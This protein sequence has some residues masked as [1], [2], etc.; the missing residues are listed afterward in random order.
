MLPRL[1]NNIIHNINDIDLDESLKPIAL[2]AMRKLQFRLQRS[3]YTR[4]F[5]TA[6]YE[7]DEILER[8]LLPTDGKIKHGIGVLV[9]C[10]EEIRHLITLAVRRITHSLS[11]SVQIDLESPALVMTAVL[12]S[13]QRFPIDMQ[14]LFPEFRHEQQ[15]LDVTFT[16]LLLVTLKACLRSS[17]LKTSLDSLPLMECIAEMEDIIR[18]G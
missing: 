5:A 8:V 1:L 3:E 6:I 18:V 2:T 10:H 7:L 14:A 17:F 15:R 9:L 16:T 12:G 11:G 4:Y 13:E